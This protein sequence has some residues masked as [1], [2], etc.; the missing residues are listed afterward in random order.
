MNG[1][2]YPEVD[3]AQDRGR[4][5]AA[6]GGL[7]QPRQRPLRGRDR[8]AGPAGHHAKA[9]RGA[10]FGDFD[11]D[12]DVDVAG[13]QRARHARPLPP[14]HRPGAHWL[15]VRLA[16][17][18]SNRSAIGARVRV[19]A[20]G[21]PQSTKCAAAAA[22]TRRTTCACT[23]AWARSAQ[24]SG[25]RC[26]GRTASRSTGPACRRPHPPARRKGRA[27]RDDRGDARARA[28]RAAAAGRLAGRPGRG[29]AGRRPRAARRGPAPGRDR[30]AQ[31]ARPAADPR[32]ATC[33]ASP[34]TTPT[35]PRAPS[36]CSPPPWT[37]FPPGSIEARRGDA[38][39]RPVALPRRP[40]G[41][42]DP[43]TSSARASAAPD[44]TRAGPRAGHGLRPDAPARQGAAGL[45]AHLRRRRPARRPPT[46]SPRR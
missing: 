22:T 28:G 14:R 23:S 4:L 39:A 20:G 43:A 2:V 46:C 11:N 13:Q 29:R 21:D 40:H 17:H 27:A 1:H 44:N 37:A 9:G 42:G 6:Q 35:T 45:G 31:V 8:A 32:V 16:G 12:G 33:S 25:S 38:G 34:T 36:S 3:A 5:R 19:A 41:R 7:P 18:A 26:A 30:S 15:A 10:A 24:W